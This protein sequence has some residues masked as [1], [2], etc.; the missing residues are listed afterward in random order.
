MSPEILL[1]GAVLVLAAAV[2]HEG[3]RRNLAQP[4][5]A[6]PET[7]R[8]MEELQREF[9]G[10][11]A[12]LAAQMATLDARLAGLADSVTG[13]EAA[14]DNQVKNL[15][16]Q[17]QAVSALF[18]NDRTRGGWGEI[19][20]KRIFESG[21]LVEGRDYTLQFDSGSG[22]PDA[23]V[24]LPGGRNLVIDAK[25]PTA[26]YEEALT[27]TDPE[28]RVGLLTEQG[29]ELERVGK[30]LATRGYGEL[31]AGGYVVMY[32]PSQAVYEAAAEAHPELLLRL[33]E[34][35]VV[36]AGPSSL[37][38]LLLS[39]G[40]LLAQYQALEQADRIVEDARELHRR[41][42]VFTGHLRK[43]GT[44]LGAAVVAFNAAVGSWSSRVSPH[45][46][47]I[48]ETVGRDEIDQPAPVDEAVRDLSDE[49][50]RVAG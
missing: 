9:A 25:F 40:S 12:A 32:L 37:Y 43:V 28:R 39:A 5:V 6:D 41:L 19:S 16:T 10:R 33:M 4:P 35:K 46:T 49:G 50:L 29:K 2:L 31:A 18:R 17:M 30:E 44:G 26:R 34:K 13:R 11:E 22:K 1:A 24:H 14:L 3:R 23:V 7:S 20:L 47:R 42:A 36:V 48:S 27:E 15:T 8:R 45:L 38:A 21:Q